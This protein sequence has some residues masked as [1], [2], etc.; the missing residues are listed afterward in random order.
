MISHEHIV[1]FNT[2]VN[3]ERLLPSE[4]APALAWM[5]RA[6]P[7]TPAKRDSTQGLLLAEDLGHLCRR[8]TP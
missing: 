6:R 2:L 5:M 4:S 7:N 3:N 8:V 1:E